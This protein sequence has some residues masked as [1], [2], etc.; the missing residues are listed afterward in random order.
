MSVYGFLYK[1]VIWKMWHK[2]YVQTL[3]K[4]DLVA[5]CFGA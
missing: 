4:V 5:A 2:T 3:C 1:S